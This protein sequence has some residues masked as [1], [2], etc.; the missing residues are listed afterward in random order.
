MNEGRI[1]GEVDREEA[2]QEKLMK[3]MTKSRG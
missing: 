3:L 2:T 1:T